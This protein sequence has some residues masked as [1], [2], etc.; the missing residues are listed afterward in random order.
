MSTDNAGQHEKDRFRTLLIN[1][2][3]ELTKTRV[4]FLFGMC[5]ESKLYSE[6]LILFLCK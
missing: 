1:L 2:L 4:D 5:S 6:S 3:K